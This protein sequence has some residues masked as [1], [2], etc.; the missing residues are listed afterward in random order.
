MSESK[1]APEP[2]VA[3]LSAQ[4]RAE[5]ALAAAKARPKPPRSQ[6]LAGLF[7]RQLTGQLV[8]EAIWVIMDANG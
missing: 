5:R 4:V 7:R 2:Y 1:V 8:Q 6:N 3:E